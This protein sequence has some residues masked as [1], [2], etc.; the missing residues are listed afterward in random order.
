MFVMS[1]YMVRCMRKTV[2]DG[3]HVISAQVTNPPCARR[4]RALYARHNASCVHANC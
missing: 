1:S 4:A 3:I 2:A